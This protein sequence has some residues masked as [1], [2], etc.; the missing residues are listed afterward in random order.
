MSIRKPSPIDPE[1]T[2]VAAL[3]WIA[4]DGARLERFLTLT[5]VDAAQIRQ[6]AGEPGFLGAVLD[7]LLFDEANLQAFAA[8]Q[9]IDPATV[10]AAR[11]RLPG[12]A[13]IHS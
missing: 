13:D 5:G 2:A 7:H 9:G 4:A 10:A 6:I 8:D 11:R 12:A 1:T 3:G